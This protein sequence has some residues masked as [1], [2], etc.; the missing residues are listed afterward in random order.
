VPST[1][2]QEN[3]VPSACVGSWRHTGEEEWERS[4]TDEAGN[5]PSGAIGGEFVVQQQHLISLRT[6]TDHEQKLLTT[7]KLNTRLDGG[8]TVF[9]TSQQNV[10]SV[11]WAIYT[12]VT[13]RPPR[14][15]K[16]I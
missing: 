6:C 12:T 11:R 8:E 14:A 5:H 10:T 16:A 2:P 13:C 1:S 7:A 3:N 9:D 15:D 4:A